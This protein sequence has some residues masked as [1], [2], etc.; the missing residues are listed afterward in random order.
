MKREP[1]NTSIL[2]SHFQSGGGLLNHTG[3]TYFHSGMI[4]S[5]SAPALPGVTTRDARLRR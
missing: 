3:G 5:V 4:R 2:L 1:V